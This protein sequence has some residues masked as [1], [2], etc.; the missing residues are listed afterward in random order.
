MATVIGIDPSFTC[1]GV[2]VWVNGLVKTFSVTTETGLARAYRET[3]IVDSV[4]RWALPGTAA[5]I[6]EGVYAN[7]FG[8]RTSLDL[9]G[10][11]DVLVYEFTRRKIP[12]GI[13][14]NNSNKKFA[15]GSGKAT[16]GDMVAYARAPL[17][18]TV[19]N[20]NEA[21]ALWLAMMGVVS[22][23]GQLN[24]WP[25]RS[26]DLRSDHPIMVANQLNRADALA[27]IDWVGGWPGLL[28]EEF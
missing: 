22:M 9:A 14:A 5:A 6:V 2:C 15:T 23:G 28:L 1:T 26:E 13:P 10:L 27:K 11:H 4:M 7:K 20:H 17:G 25:P 8:G 21:D 18:V 24:G 12:V 16:K 19:A 3:T